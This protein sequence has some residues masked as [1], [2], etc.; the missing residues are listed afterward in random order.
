MILKFGFYLP[1]LLNQKK[2]LD[3]AINTGR[4]HIVK[5]AYNIAPPYYSKISDFTI[6]LGIFLPSAVL[7][8]VANNNKGIILD[9]LYMHNDNNRN[10]LSHLNSIFQYSIY[11]YSPIIL[12]EYVMYVQHSCI[13]LHK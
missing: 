3:L 5:D 10:L 2:F 9:V 6:G 12:V 1:L 8:C 4:C 7:E 13:K 11:I